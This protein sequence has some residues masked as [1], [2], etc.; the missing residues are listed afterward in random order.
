MLMLAAPGALDQ[1]EASILALPVPKD[2]EQVLLHPPK[3]KPFFSR[4]KDDA[5]AGEAPVADDVEA[6]DDMDPLD[7]D[8]VTEPD[9][10]D[11]D[12]DA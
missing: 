9:D 2:A 6:A 4:K 7:D 5:A 11:A 12:H 10:D 3:A 1:W 8:G